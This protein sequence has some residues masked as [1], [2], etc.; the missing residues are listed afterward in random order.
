MNLKELIEPIFLKKIVGNIEQIEINGIEVD[1]RKIQVG[2][3]FICLPGFTVDGHEFAQAAIDKGAVALVC[4]KELPVN[5]PQIIVKSSRYA[6]AVLSDMFFNH[7]TQKLKVIG[8]TGTNG[9]TTTTHLI[10]KIFADGGHLSGLIGTIKMKIGDKVY[11]MKNTTPEAIT[12]Q[13]SFSE[14]VK[15]GSEYAIMEVSS[16]ALDLGRVRGVD[17]NIAVFTNLTQDHLDYHVTMERYKEAKGLLFSQLGNS[18][19]SSPKGKKYA[20]LNSDDKATEYYT[21][22]TAAEVVTYG[23][24]QPANIKATN[25][26]TSSNGTTFILETPQGNIEIQLQMI[27][28]FSVYNALAAISVAYIEGYSLEQIKNSLEE[29]KGVD[30]RFEAVNEGQDFT[31]I[32]D[33]AHTPDSLE[34]VLKT[35]REFAKGKVYCIFGAGGDRDKTKRPIMGSIAVQYSDIAVVTSDNPRSEDPNTIIKDVLVG[36]EKEEH[37]AG[38]YIAITDR[39]EAIEYAIAN[40][41]KDD[42]VLIAGKGHETYQIIKDQVHHFD[43]REIAKEAIRRKEQ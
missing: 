9:K 8:V 1:S 33:Y 41:H 28:M 39:K 34:N 25:I 30:G 23:I 32:V 35:I 4:E 29:I 17:Y 18:F 16:H 5:I 40:A 27:G 3:L 24:N 36:I 31:V 42:V 43:D 20:V 2:D 19:A 14:M 13:K 6:M 15:V 10:E 22:I 26:K 7:P 38:E 12:L 37:L 11:D 21:K